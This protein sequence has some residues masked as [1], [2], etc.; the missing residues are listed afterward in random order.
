MT[1]MDKF[2]EYNP[3][4]LSGGQKQRVALAGALAMETDLIIFDEST[5][6]LD[7]QGVKE[8]TKVI[9]NLKQEVN[10]TIITITHNI[11]EVLTADSVIILDE[12]RIIKQGCPKEVLSDMSLLDS[13]GLDTPEC[14]KLISLIK[15]MNISD[16][17]KWEKILWELAFKM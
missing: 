6:M 7:P 10:K 14:V 12:G 15:E 11:E 1:K 9:K 8:I 4:Q 13:L 3:E 2:L 5:S 16:S 17:D